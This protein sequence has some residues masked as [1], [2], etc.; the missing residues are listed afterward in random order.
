MR[1][2]TAVFPQ[3]YRA[4]RL[5]DH[6]RRHHS[7]G[8]ADGAVVELGG[9]D[10]RAVLAGRFADEDVLA[11]RAL[12]DAFGGSVVVDIEDRAAS[13]RGGHS[14][15]GRAGFFSPTIHIS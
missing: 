5:L 1:V 9:G 2:M 7:L 14:G 12:I 11:V 6:L 13:A 10:E 3:A 15:G 4:D 8:A